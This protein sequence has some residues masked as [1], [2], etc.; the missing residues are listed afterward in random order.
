MSCDG[1]VP[2]SRK[3]AELLEALAQREGFSQ[4][5]LDGVQ[6]IKSSHT[7][8]QRPIV[9]RPCIVIV[10]QGR[11]VGYF[12][13]SIVTYDPDNYLVLSVPMPFECA[14]AKADEQEPFLALSVD[15]D[16]SVLGELVMELGHFASDVPKPCAAYSSRPTQKLRDAA[17]RLAELLQSQ[18]D[19]RILGR[20]AVREIHYRVLQ[21]EQSPMLLA[22]TGVRGVFSHIARALH[23]IHAEYH[24]PLDVQFLAS[25]ANMSVPVFHRH[26]KTITSLSPIQYLKSIRLHKARMLMAQNGHSVKTAAAEVGYASQS[27][28]S[29]EFKRFFG[30]SPMEETARTRDIGF[31]R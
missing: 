24:N 18:E 30:T 7:Q 23:R 17:L 1:N 4:T 26:F 22:M 19:T 2:D 13:D 31:P 6:V 12:G 14:I 11:K 15:V 8:P 20:Q 5:L 16:A 9:Y 3:M 27:Q 21:G 29:R 25:E 28:F 10:V